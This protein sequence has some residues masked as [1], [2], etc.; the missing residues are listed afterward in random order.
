M[1]DGVPAAG[2][3]RE[4][5]GIEVALGLLA[6]GRP[7]ARAARASPSARPCS[8]S[9]ARRCRR[10]PSGATARGST[11]SPIA[12]TRRFKGAGVTRSSLAWALATAV[13][14]SG[15]AE[16]AGGEQAHRQGQRLVV[17]EHHRRQLE[18]RD[19]HVGAVAAA[20]GGD[21]D[22]DLLER[23]DVAAH[24]SADRPRAASPARSRRGG[25]GS[26]AARGPPARASRG[27]T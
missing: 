6:P 20:L 21:R 19:Q 10:A 22:A 9:R 1:A 4:A 24:R 15:E 23:H 7:V 27:G 16:P 2:A 5:V 13:A 8:V 11:V 18:A 17:G 14:A 25:R 26:G 12:R 3:I